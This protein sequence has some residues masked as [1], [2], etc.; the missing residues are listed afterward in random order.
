MG[1]TTTSINLASGL[2]IRGYKTLLV[3]LDPQANASSGLG[4]KPE[5]ADESICRILAE[6]C[7][8][9][10]ISIIKQTVVQS[11]DIAPSHINMARQQK[12]LI[13]AVDRQ[14]VLARKLDKIKEVYD[15]IIVDC[16][17]TL[18]TLSENGIFAANCIIVPCDRGK[19]ALEGFG[20]LAETISELKN[21]RF[22]FES[23]L[24]TL[25]TM[26]KKR[27]PLSEWLTSQIDATMFKR[28]ET[29]IRESSPLKLSVIAEQPIYNYSKRSSGAKDYNALTDE[30]VNLWSVK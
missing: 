9:E 27:D 14:K 16:P 17:P 24:R 3:D 25:L 21:S 28:L 5:S 23:H 7:K 20:D 26:Q 10:I 30:V 6:R 2:A 19:W 13:C 8:D 18:D 12:T 15:Y 4:A 22:S 29:V 1:K 11:L